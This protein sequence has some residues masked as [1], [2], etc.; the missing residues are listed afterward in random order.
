MS[1]ALGRKKLELA[2]D[3]MRDAEGMSGAG[4]NRR[5]FGVPYNDCFQHDHERFNRDLHGGWDLADRLI[6]E[7]K[8][9]YVHNFHRSHG[10][11]PRGHAFEYGTKWVCN[12]C[13]EEGV[14]KPW[15]SIKVFMDGNAWCCIGLGFVSLQASDNYAF[16]E[17]REQAIANYGELMSTKVAA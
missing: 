8:L 13:G 15:W 9:Y 2:Q 10:N 16:G 17:S 14:D 1:S 6:A 4:F 11:C 7:G 3:I 5:V 12:T